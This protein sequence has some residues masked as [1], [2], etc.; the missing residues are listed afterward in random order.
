MMKRVLICL[1]ACVILLMTAQT[2]LAADETDGDCIYTLVDADG[3]VLT[4][5]AARMYEGDEYISSDNRYYRVAFVDDARCIA[6]AEEIGQATIDEAAFAAFLSAHAASD[7]AADDAKLICMYST[8]S[9]ESYVPSDGASS[10]WENAGIYDVGEA[11][12]ESLEAHGI[13]VEYS[14]ESFLPHDA[15]AYSRSRGTVEEYAKQLPDAIIDIH[16]DGVEAE[17]YETEVDGE[18]TSMVRLFVGRSNQNAE[19]NKAF[20]QRLKAVADAA[21]PG[22]VKDIFIGKGNYNQELYPQ[23]ILL[24]FGTYEIEKEKAISATE[25][26]ADVIDEVLFGSTAQASTGEKNANAAKGIAWAVG[27]AIVLAAIYALAAT[28]RLGPAWSK[29]KNGAQEMGAGLFGRS[30]K[31]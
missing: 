28:G 24:E 14:H 6:T 27:V 29:L 16:R 13:T 25:Y 8:H 3:A 10:L 7:P 20:A 19:E 18:D 12:K 17:E 22:L 11:L 2:A 31:K 1:C 15:D 21:Y 9:D 4:R 30:R 5:R 26:M 23:A